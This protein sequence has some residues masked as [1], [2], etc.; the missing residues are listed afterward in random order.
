D[1]EKGNW[2]GFLFQDRGA[3]GR[4]PVVVPCRWIDGWPI[5]GD[6]EGKVP[7]TMQLPILGEEP[8]P[9]VI[10][11]DFSATK[12]ALN[13]QWNHNPDNALWSLTE[14]A[15][16]MRLKTGKVVENIFHARNMLS[17]RTEGPACRGIVSIDVS[18]MADGDVT[19]LT[20]YCSEPGTIE[21][22]MEGNKKYL[23]MTDRLVEKERIELTKNIIYLRLD[24][25]F[26]NGTDKANFYYSLDNSEWKQLGTEFQMVYNLHHFMGNRFGIFNYA[27]KAAGGYVDVDFFKYTRL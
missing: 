18:N 21:V 14:R 2:Y 3:L 4:V 24:C 17:Q 8:K 9:L 7:L 10:S 1:D 11:D 5:M 20:A 19:G 23:V 22:R 15:G 27:T 25:D 16:Y 12:L 13:W 26:N 6:E